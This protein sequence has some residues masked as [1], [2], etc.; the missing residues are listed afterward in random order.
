[1]KI[2]IPPRGW[3]LFLSCLEKPRSL[4]EVS[5]EL[6][7]KGQSAFSNRYEGKPLVEWMMDKGFLEFAGKKGREIKYSSRIEWFFE[8]DFWRKDW[9]KSSLFN[10]D[11]IKILYEFETE[12]TKIFERLGGEFLRF[13]AS[14]M[15]IVAIEIFLEEKAKRERIINKKLFSKITS[16]VNAGYKAKIRALEIEITD[17]KYK[18]DIYN[19]KFFI[20]Q[21][22]TILNLSHANLNVGAYISKIRPIINKHRD[23]VI[24]LVLQKT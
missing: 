11:N 19:N 22:Y 2:Y 16:I 21:L 12:K 5:K 14:Y 17:E 20:E 1:M 7:Y 9:V 13:I 24:K 10:L 15:I 18:K 23:D 3:I 6:G 8:E 4:K